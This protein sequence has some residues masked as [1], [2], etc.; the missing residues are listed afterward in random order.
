MR[1]P[2]SIVL[3]LVFLLGGDLCVRAVEGEAEW[4]VVVGNYCL[5][6]HDGLSAKGDLDL[7][8]LLDAGEAGLHA[9]EWE[10]V[11]RQ[12]GAR[13]MPPVGKDRP[14]DGEYEAAVASLTAELDANAAAGALW[15]GRTETLRRLTRTEYANCVRDLLGVEIDV[16]ELLPAD[17]SGHGFDNITVGDLS[18]ALLERYISAAQKISRLAVGA[19]MGQPEGRTIRLA[20]DLTQEEHV[21]GLPLGTRGGA[22]IRHTFP[23]DGEYEVQVL[24]TRDRN[25]M[26][27]GLNGKHVLEFLL[28][29]EQAAEFELSP[30][31]GKQ[32]HTHYDANLKAR[33]AVE[34]GPRDLGVTFRKWPSSLE[35]TLREP[36]DAHFNYHRHPRLSPAIY[37]VTITGPFEDAGR[38]ETP[39][40]ERIFGGRAAAEADDDGDGDGNDE[41]VAREVLAGLLRRAWRRDVGDGDVERVMPFFRDGL[42][43]GGSFD[44]GM[45]A[46]LAAVLVSREFLF[47][48]EPD[49]EGVA[50]GTAYRV[51]DEELASR[52]SFFL[53]SSLPDERLLDLAAAG[54][55]HRPRV[56]AR[57]VKRMLVDERAESLVTN[58]ADQW[59]YLRNL[60]SITPDGRLFP[61]FDDN[62]RQAFRRET[63]WL[64]GTVVREDRSVLDLIGAEETYLNERLAKHYGIPRV[65]GTRFRRVALDGDE[66]RGGLLRQGS[67]LTV[68]SYATRTSPVIRGHWILENL[69]GT[70]PPPPPP[71]VPNLEDTAVDDDLP[72]RERLAIH[73]E[74]AACASCH[75][76]MDP[77]GFALE[78]YDA[79]GRRRESERGMAIDATG[80]LPDGRE[81][82]G[83][84]GLEAGVMNRPEIFVRTLAEKLLVF[85]LGRGVE[86]EDA[87]AIREIVR[88]SAREGYTFSSL[89]TAIVQSPL[90]TMRMTE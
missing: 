59:L 7:E 39:S 62:L 52:L 60:D 51:S 33:I 43:T 88:G 46:A 65:Y 32:G 5:D 20:P 85:G 40:R 71:D 68:T 76:V 87:P 89:V 23:R 48:T 13:Q 2:Q 54:K 57:E 6:C 31:K 86:P 80:S 90:F 41:V 9:G 10:R 77:V 75:D 53:W 83:V 67:I 25:E 70:P 49:P 21:E 69:L 45:E 11:L 73:R 18:P 26:V 74:N 29:G 4:R 55:L 81:F 64:F 36:Y 63:E 38:G 42:A 44:A 8:G 27:E 37:Q 72:M 82:V 34:A 15:A 79:V 22:L 35:G 16:S 3:C 1:F 47:R 12:L 17:Q 66:M 24:L 30:P 61:G 14:E 84:E 50:P 19:P 56:L 78:H 58:F 28:D